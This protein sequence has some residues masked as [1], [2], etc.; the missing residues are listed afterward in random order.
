MGGAFWSAYVQCPED[1]FNF[2]DSNYA[3]IVR[4][5]LEQLDLYNRLHERYPHCFSLSR[6]SAAAEKAFKKGHLISPIGIEGLHQIGNSISNLRLFYELGVRYSTLTHNCHNTYADAALV[7]DAKGDVMASKPYWGGVSPKGRALINEMNRMGMIVDLSHVS[8]DVMLDTL[9]GAPQKGWNGSLAAP[10][11]S[12]SSAYALCSHPRN[13]PDDVLQLVKKRGALVMINFAPAFISCKAGNNKNGLPDTV[14]EGATLKRV[15]E[16]IKHIGESIGYDYVGIGTDFD[17]I[18][19][20]PQGL[21]DVS[22]FPDLVTEMLRQG[23]SDK[24][25][26]KVVGRNLLRVWKEVDEVAAKLQKE[27]LPLEDDITPLARSK[28]L[29]DIYV[30]GDRT[31]FV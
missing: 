25:A 15:V 10:I 8:K 2:S 29:D 4:A 26:A 18:P 14:P 20:T 5:T 6:D 21:N 27:T 19:S 13:V 22:K 28:Y 1:G 3:P 30:S 12:H 17:G 9:G 31:A 23:V 16:H 7:N 24:D 11:F